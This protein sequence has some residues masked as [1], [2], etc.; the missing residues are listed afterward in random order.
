[1]EDALDP[2]NSSVKPDIAS[3]LG[4]LDT[5]MDNIVNARAELG[6]RQNRIEL[7][8][9]RIDFQE[10]TAKRMLSDNEDADIEQVIT[11][12]TSQESVHRAALS[13]GAR[14]I[15]PSLMDFLR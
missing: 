14:I 15:Q 9:D 8:E 3:F 10:V 1:M 13:V 11:D 7:M 6:A 4:K 2:N 5:H 12:L